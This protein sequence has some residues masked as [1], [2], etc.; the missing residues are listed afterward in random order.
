M[1]SRSG[2][3]RQPADD[4]SSFDI[5]RQSPEQIAQ[6]FARWKEQRKRLAREAEQEP[7]QNGSGQN[8]AAPQVVRFTPAA[9]VPAQPEPEPDPEP[10]DGREGAPGVRQYSADFSAILTSRDQLDARRVKHLKLPAAVITAPAR[11]AH[12]SGMRWT[13]AIAVS[14][15]ALTAAAGAAY[16]SQQ[17]VASVRP[18]AAVAVAKPARPQPAVEQ[19]LETQAAAPLLPA[20]TR[21][22]EA[23]PW[24]TALLIDT[25]SSPPLVEASSSPPIV[26]VAQKPLSANHKSIQ[27]TSSSAD[28]PAPSVPIVQVSAEAPGDFVTSAGGSS[29]TAEAV[30]EAT[31]PRRQAANSAE[32]GNQRD[33]LQLDPGTAPTAGSASSSTTDRN[34]SA[35][36]SHTADGQNDPS[37]NGTA[38]G[39]SVGSSADA[40]SSGGSSSNAGGSA[41]TGSSGASASGSNTAS[42]A[43]SGSGGDTSVGGASSSASGSADGSGASPGAS[44]DTGTSADGTGTSSNGSS[45][46]SSSGSVG[47]LG[48]AMGGA[49]DGDVGGVHDAVGGALG[50]MGKAADGIGKPDG[51]GKG[52]SAGGKGKGKDKSKDKSKDKDKDKGGHKGGGKGKG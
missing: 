18:P 2:A 49:V 51:K 27:T 22:P 14:F 6:L 45:D 36:A 35:I 25:A 46:G 34:G 30:H 21:L 42:G 9:R 38:G 41:G 47:G 50:G 3:I 1:S 20:A 40:S 32:R 28:G 5:S 13:L 39:S 17:E 33:R 11:P 12:G 29:V 15:I 24:S 48:D 19:P 44:G 4:G 7:G 8:S 31:P 10:V 52:A 37:G 23:E 43:S 16:W 26:E